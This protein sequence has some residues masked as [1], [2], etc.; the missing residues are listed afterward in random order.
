MTNNPVSGERADLLEFLGKH[1]HFLRHTAQG[2]TDEQASTRSTASELTIGGVIKHV[3]ATEAHWAGFAQG[4]GG[5]LPTEYTPEVIAAW[6][7]QFRLVEG[8][9]LA[10]VLAEYEKV[11][12][13]TDELVRTLDLDVSFELPSAPWQPPGVF[14]TV[15]RVF[16]HIA[17]E[18]AQ[19]SGHADIIRETI[20]G[21]KT[22][23]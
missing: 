1:R 3:S 5:N 9:T 8:E 12:A 22:M 6:Q 16:F 18:T 4:K 13:A 20:D 2:L 10:D 7:D 14:W 23:G 11:A 21:Q 19:H 15:R 17:A